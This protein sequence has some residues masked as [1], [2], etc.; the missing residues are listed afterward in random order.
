MGLF[1][2]VRK[3]R[4]SCRSFAASAGCNN[5]IVLVNLCFS[6]ALANDSCDSAMSDSR[7]QGRSWYHYIFLSFI[8][9]ENYTYS[10]SCTQEV[11]K[12]GIILEAT[13]IFI[14]DQDFVGN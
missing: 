6:V 12:N 9:N 8:Y 3:V 11:F 5:Q 2:P 14:L 1:L 13:V 4:A 7:V 10:V